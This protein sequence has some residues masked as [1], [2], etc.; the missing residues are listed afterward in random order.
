[1]SHVHKVPL[2]G[3][4]VEEIGRSADIPSQHKLLGLEAIILVHDLLQ[5]SGNLPQVLIPAVLCLVD[6][7][8]HCVHEG[9]VVPIHLAVGQR[10]I[11]SGASIVNLEQL[12][13]RTE[14]LA[15][16]IPFLV[17]ENLKGAPFGELVH[18]QQNILITARGK[19]PRKPRCT[20]SMGDPHGT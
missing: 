17:R 15:F 5:S 19:G 3:G 10:P 13:D 8:Q 4:M 20:V 1:M 18:D 9:A 11:R 6:I 12:A 16:K 2:S 14:K 7:P